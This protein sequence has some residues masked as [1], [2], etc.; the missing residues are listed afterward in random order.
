M[1]SIVVL[2]MLKD[3]SVTQAVTYSIEVVISWKRCKI[4]T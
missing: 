3:F 2:S 4:V 1:Y